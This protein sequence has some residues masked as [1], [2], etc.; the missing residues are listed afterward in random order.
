MDRETVD[1]IKRHFGVVAEDLRKEIRLV[2]ESVSAHRGETSREFAAVR[3][4]FRHE[5]NE[6][7]ALIR[8]SYGQL[9]QRLITLET[10]VSDLRARLEK[11]ET[12]LGH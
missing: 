4:E 11:V 9:D 6:V 5:I 1:E 12:R 8:L 2:G 3:A 7:K 10:D